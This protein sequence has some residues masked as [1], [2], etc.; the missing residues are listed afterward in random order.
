[1][2]PEAAVAFLPSL[3]AGHLWSAPD[4]SLPCAAAATADP[5]PPRRPARLALVVARASPGRAVA[6]AA[7]ASGRRAPPPAPRWGLAPMVTAEQGV[8]TVAVELEAYL[9]GRA[10]PTLGGG[11]TRVWMHPAVDGA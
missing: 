7:A 5:S 11:G 9:G 8:A 4:H 3:T 6:A 10:G 2:A 1:M